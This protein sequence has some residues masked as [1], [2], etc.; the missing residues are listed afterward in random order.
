MKK[1]IKYLTLILTYGHFLLQIGQNQQSQLKN[2]KK[3]TRGLT[4]TVYYLVEKKILFKQVIW[5]Y[6]ELVE[7]E[8]HTIL[9]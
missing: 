5:N 6:L 3:S 2:K 9:L 8:S 7:I 1:K 4:G